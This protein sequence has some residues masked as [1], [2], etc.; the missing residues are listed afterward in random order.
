MA[1]HLGTDV[2]EP[3]PPHAPGLL[4]TVGHLIARKRHADVLR[5]VALLRDRHPAL[6]TTY[7]DGPA[8]P[9]QRV[10]EGAPLALTVTSLMVRP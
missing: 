6:R 8:G 9:V 2:P 5:A 3:E 1:V 10:A 7:A 4:V